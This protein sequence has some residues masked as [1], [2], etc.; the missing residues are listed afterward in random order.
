[1]NITDKFEQIT[2]LLAKNRFIAVLEKVAAPLMSP[3][4]ADCV[5]GEYFPHQITQR[6]VPG[7]DQ[8]MKVVG[9]KGPG[10]ALTT[11]LEQSLF[12]PAKKIVAVPFA[13]KNLLTIMAADDNVV[14]SAGEVDSLMSGHR[15]TILDQET[16]S[17]KLL[18]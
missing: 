15:T 1:V 13:E 16:M 8:E 10:Q 12:E 11:G 2:L 9:E 18:S 17:I 6:S 7:T 5:P 3:V 14:D 4:K